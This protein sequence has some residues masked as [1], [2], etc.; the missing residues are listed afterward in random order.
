[1]KRDDL[2]FELPDGRVLLLD[3]P[4]TEKEL[5]FV[6]TP[7][8]IAAMTALADLI[9]ANSQEQIHSSQEAYDK[10]LKMHGIIRV[11]FER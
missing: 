9:A 1:M 3:E 4:F 5:E 8:G 11:G 7:E 10:M 2:H 6:K